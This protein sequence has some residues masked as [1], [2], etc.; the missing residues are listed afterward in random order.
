MISEIYFSLDLIRPVSFLV[1]L[2]FNTEHNR[3]TF[4]LQLAM[5]ALEIIKTMG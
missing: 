3:N 2:V 5:G 4:L 1:K